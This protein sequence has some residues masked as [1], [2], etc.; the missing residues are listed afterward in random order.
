MINADVTRELLHGSP[1]ALAEASAVPK[2]SGIRASSI[3]FTGLPAFPR[4]RALTDGQI[5]LLVSA[6]LFAVGAW[7]LALVEVPPYQDLP[8]HLATSTVIENLRAYPEY[9]FNGFFKTN[10]AL[11]AW[12]YLV[13]KVTGV[14][15]A[16]RLFALITLGANALVWPRFVLYITGSRRRMLAASLFAWPMVH[17]WFVSMG[18]LDFSI[19]VPL[20]FG[21]LM[22]LDRQRTR[23]SVARASLVVGLGALTW[24]A[25]VFPLLVVHLLVLIEAARKPSWRERASTLRA[26]ALPL[27]P[28]TLLALFSVGEQVRDAVGPMTGFMDYQKLLAPWELLYNLWAEW[29]WGYSNLTLSTLVPCVGLAVLGLAGVVRA[30]RTRS[31]T[32]TF[33][34]P[35]ALL[36]LVVLYAFVPYK[37]TNWFHVNSRLIPYF[38]MGLMLYLPERL[39]RAAALALGLSGLLYTAGMGIDYVRLDRDRQEFV[40]GLEAV[41][42][43]ARLLPMLF[44]HKGASANTRNLM[45]MWGYYVVERR[46]AS[47]LLFA[48]SRSFPVTYSSPPPVRFN[49]LVLE[50]FAPEMATPGLVCKA[51]ARWE[52]CDALFQ[53]TWRNFWNDATPRFDHVLLWDAPPEAIAVVP[54][55]YKPVFQRGRL[56]IL[57]R[58]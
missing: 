4:T 39:P 58:N 22:A 57:A 26:Y 53:S 20:S 23:P 18:M 5:A 38:W 6:L 33:F 1:D 29:F 32:P 8:N 30:R 44:N 52:E 10:A 47:P 49:H 50:S 24:Y 51:A 28:V 15:L 16:A 36:V 42:E 14:K 7:P 27:A 2:S 43:G 3:T 21:L 37:M 45:H 34:S 40:A 48:H 17:H 35:A 46:T 9:T 41:P 55:A 56:S 11:F 54:S 19:A 13:G 31:E 12:L 25:H